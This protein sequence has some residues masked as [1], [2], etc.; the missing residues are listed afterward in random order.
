[1]DHIFGDSD[2]ISFGSS[3]PQDIWSSVTHT[4]PTT[5]SNHRPSVSRS[6]PSNFYPSATKP[7]R[8]NTPRPR[9]TPSYIQEPAV[10]DNTPALSRLIAGMKA[11][12]L[13]REEDTSVV[14]VVA[15]SQQ[16][17]SDP[18]FLV[19]QDDT[20]V[21][22]GSGFWTITRAWHTYPT[23]PDMRLIFSEKD[24]IRAWILTD[25]SIDVSAFELILP[26][27]GFP[28]IYATRDVIASFRN[29]I[30]NTEFLESCRFFELFADGTTSRRIGDIESIVADTAMTTSL[31]FRAGNTSFAFSHLPI[32]SS[33][34][35]ASVNF[36]FQNGTEMFSCNNESFVTGEVL[37]LKA[38]NMVRNSMKFTFDTFFADGLSIGVVAG[39][40]LTDREQLS[41]NGVLTFTLEEDVRA[42]TI[43]G[44][45]FIDS[46]G[47][48]HAYEMMYIH[49]EIIK[50]IR[51]TYEKFLLDN[52]KIERWELVQWLRREITKYCYLLTGRTP[53]VMPI[54]IER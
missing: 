18:L 3:K 29:S 15:L 21:V 22:V 50:G 43:A 8:D 5:V 24:R 48:V 39:Y 40:A 54:V 19:R 32:V 11:S 31:G 10:I 25:A 1:M 12:F 36:T 6:A 14:R 38:S 13:P 46:R 34:L 51:S 17:N 9:L 28:P 30:K 37:S 44:H 7:A 42:R 2:D 35:G 53:I 49:K 52:P 45:I 4:R 27:L 41:E 26:T 23:F 33:D 47:F 16:T 20:T